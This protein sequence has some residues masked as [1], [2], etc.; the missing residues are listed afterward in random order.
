MDVMF[1]GN[2]NIILQN[3][4]QVFDVFTDSFS[5]KMTQTEVDIKFFSVESYEQFKRAILFKYPTTP[6]TKYLQRDC[7]QIEVEGG[8]NR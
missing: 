4:Q 1:F 2:K 5:V 8:R 6:W 7:A 3:I